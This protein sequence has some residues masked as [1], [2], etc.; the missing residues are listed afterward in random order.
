[1]LAHL[2]QL[3]IIQL[4]L[5]FENRERDIDLANIVQIA[6]NLYLLAGGLRQLHPAGKL[7]GDFPTMMLWVA[8]KLL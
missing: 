6:G 8:V 2:T 4:A 5:F 7:A 1:V 3:V